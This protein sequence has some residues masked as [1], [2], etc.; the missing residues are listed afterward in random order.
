MSKNRDPLALSPHWHVDCS[1][2]AELPDDRVVSGRFLIN[3][4]FGAGTLVLLMLAG[5]KLA[6]FLSLRSNIA[7]WNRRIADSRVE[8]ASIK[9][10]QRDYIGTAR[11]IEMAHTLI[12]GRL[13]VF[14]FVTEL[15]RTRPDKMVINSIESNEAGIVVRGTLGE[16]S[17]QA[18]LLI[19]K[20]VEQLRRDPEIAPCFRK[21]G[22]NVTSFEFNRLTDQ[23]D[24]ELTFQFA[25]NSP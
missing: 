16:S 19:G 20:Y 13:M 15:G 12:K 22:I 5:L 14:A 8:L 1:L 4:P 6:N 2:A 25:P 21:D 7:D 24:F 17:E 3:L 10:M 18:T 23:Q 11:K 9:Q